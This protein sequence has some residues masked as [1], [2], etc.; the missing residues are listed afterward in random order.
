MDIY[1]VLAGGDD[2][3]LIGPWNR[4]IEL[5]VLLHKTFADYVCYNEQV[6]FSAGI[7]I[8]K[9]HTPLD[10][11]SDAA[12]TALEKS[13]EEGRNKGGC[14]TIFSETADWH[15]FKELTKIKDTLQ[16]WRDNELINN[17]MIYRLND[18]LDMAGLEKQIMTNEKRIYLEDMDC[19]KWRALFSYTTARNVGKGL[20]EEE[21]KEMLKQFS[22]V[23]AWLEEY[24]GK[25]K[26]ALWHII[27]NYR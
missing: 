24:G 11:L 16:S 26:I 3:F 7:S 8:H 14:I 23:A 13:K 20:K 6:H 22:Q 15:E 10:K 19:L 25:L 17:A 1:T 5:S 18:F 4:I 27:Y 12:E 2:L 9:P 21:K